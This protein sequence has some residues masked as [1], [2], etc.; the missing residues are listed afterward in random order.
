LTAEPV[1]VGP[2]ST[3]VMGNLG[4]NPTAAIQA[5][6]F[7]GYV[8]ERAAIAAGASFTG[9]GTDSRVGLQQHVRMNVKNCASCGRG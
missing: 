6:S 2:V 4:W 7:V 8:E 3:T 5:G 1:T 9:E